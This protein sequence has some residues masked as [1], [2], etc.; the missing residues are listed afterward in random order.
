VNYQRLTAMRFGI[1]EEVI[2]KTHLG[3]AARLSTYALM[4]GLVVM[5]ILDNGFG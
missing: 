1:S 3:S 4:V 5:M 2:P